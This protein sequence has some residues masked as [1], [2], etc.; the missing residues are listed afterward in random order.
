MKKSYNKTKFLILKKANIDVT[1]HIFSF[2]SEFEV[3]MF[4]D[5]DKGRLSKL[6]KNYLISN[7]DIHTKQRY[8]IARELLLDKKLRPYLRNNTHVD[9]SNL[10]ANLDNIIIDK[11]KGYINPD[12]SEF[13]ILTLCSI[14]VGIS[15]NIV[16]AKYVYQDQKNISAITSIAFGG[17]LTVI[18]LLGF[19][20]RY[21][22]I[23]Q[24]KYTENNICKMKALVSKF[25]NLKLAQSPKPLIFSHRINI[26]SDSKTSSFRDEYKSIPSP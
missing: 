15:L 17:L 4:V 26:A 6:L 21:Q 24:K 18:G 7:L 11:P 25:P 12:S 23:N 9:L 19:I 13:M 22:S 20:L 1:K 8:Q 3:V 2:L 5:G 10:F 16:G 14:T